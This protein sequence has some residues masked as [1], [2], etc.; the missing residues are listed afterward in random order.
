MLGVSQLSDVISIESDGAKRPIYA[1][2]VIATVKSNDSK[3][4]VEEQP[5]L[6]H[7]HQKAA[8]AD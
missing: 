1:G 5:H 6:T 7:V 3:W 2:N 8:H 4:I